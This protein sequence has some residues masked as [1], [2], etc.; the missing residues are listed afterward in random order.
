MVKKIKSVKRYN[1]YYK[2]YSFSKPDTEVAAEILDLESH[3]DEKGLLLGEIK[4]TEQGEPEE[5]NSYEYENGKLIFH[6]LEYLLDE[7]S[8]S[9]KLVRDANGRL[10]EEIKYYGNEAGE[11]TE[12]F[13]FENGEVSGRKFYDE[14]N[15]FTHRDEF[16]YNDKKQIISNISYD[17]GDK[18]GEKILVERSDDGLLTTE[19]SYDASG[20]IVSINKLKL[21]AKLKE[22][23]QLETNAGGKLISRTRFIYDENDLLIEKQTTDFYSKTERFTYNEKK[24]CTCVELF[25]QN[26][27]LIRKQLFEYDSE[28]QIVS[29]QLYEMDR[30][31]G[32]RDK[33]VGTRIEYEFYK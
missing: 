29:E 25:D 15:N 16:T 4:Y 6:K 24:Q 8:E 10:T 12:Y 27:I 2:S 9:Q 7:N 22:E 28:N 30:A 31:R 17:D 23:E 26:G 18:A 20:K 11:R 19:T 1:Q 3:F 13:Y 5:K 21:N 33:H 32:G 14:E